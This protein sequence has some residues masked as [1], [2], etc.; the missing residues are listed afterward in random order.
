[1]V[2]TFRFEGLA[3]KFP[4]REFIS[5]LAEGLNVRSS[6]LRML[7]LGEGVAV[8]LWSNAQHNL[9]RPPPVVSYLDPQTHAIPQGE[10]MEG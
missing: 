2:S 4:L 6:E 9:S 1:M 10:P 7:T 3:H 8:D 5:T